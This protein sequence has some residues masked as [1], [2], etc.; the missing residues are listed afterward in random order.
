MESLKPQ[1]AG[2]KLLIPAISEAASL[3]ATLRCVTGR[4]ESAGLSKI[5]AVE[6]QIQA[7]LDEFAQAVDVEVG[8]LVWGEAKRGWWVL[9]LEWTCNFS[10]F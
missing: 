3:Q 10:A 5:Q 8:G 9:S 2:V 1:T 6:T 4:D 7:Q